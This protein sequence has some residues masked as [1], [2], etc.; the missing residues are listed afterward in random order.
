MTRHSE[1]CSGVPSYNALIVKNIWH[2]DK[3][4][5]ITLKYA[6]RRKKWTL[7]LSGEKKAQAMLESVGNQEKL[8]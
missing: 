5:V 3:V 4:R 6:L 8:K 2:L 7:K 1:K